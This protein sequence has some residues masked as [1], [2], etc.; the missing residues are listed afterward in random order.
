MKSSAQLYKAKI[1]AMATLALLD[2]AVG[3][4]PKISIVS[5]T[6]CS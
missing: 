4:T 1:L 2:S 6:E 3:A 5:K